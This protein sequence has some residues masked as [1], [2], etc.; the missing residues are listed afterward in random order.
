MPFSYPVLR[1]T[2]GLLDIPALSLCGKLTSEP[3][4]Q[5]TLTPSIDETSPLQCRFTNNV[6]SIASCQLIVVDRLRYNP[7]LP[8]VHIRGK[9][10]RSLLPYRGSVPG[11]M[12][13]NP[14]GTLGEIHNPLRKR[15]LLNHSPS[16]F[17]SLSLCILVM[18]CYLRRYT[19]YAT[20]TLQALLIVWT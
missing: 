3:R 9:C 12:F 16:A 18:P 7:L 20:G 2:L 15:L 5:V 19:K 4:V 6:T 17:V 10:R 13:S 11:T 8:L 1:P 14:F